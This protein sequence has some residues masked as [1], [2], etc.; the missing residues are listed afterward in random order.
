MLTLGA[1]IALGAAYFSDLSERKELP[2]EGE[3]QL[4]DATLWDLI[5]SGGNVLGDMTFRQAVHQDPRRVEA[6]ITQ[7]V[8]LPLYAVMTTTLPPETDDFRRAAYMER[9]ELLREAGPITA[10]TLA[11]VMEFESEEYLPILEQALFPMAG[12]G[13]ATAQAIQAQVEAYGEALL[14]GLR[15]GRA[16]SLQAA[17]MSDAESATAWR[18]IGD[19]IKRTWE[20]IKARLDH[21]GSPVLELP[22]NLP[23]EDMEEELR[24]RLAD[25]DMAIMPVGPADPA[26]YGAL[27]SSW[28]VHA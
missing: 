3:R 9:N 12:R 10:T 5:I 26:D 15:E 23:P 7:R 14:R 18:Q 17:A 21:L 2:D 24:E 22:W 11:V 13:D 6:L 1:L 20:P 4:P 25:E 28:T 19:V 8:Q 27:F 16:I